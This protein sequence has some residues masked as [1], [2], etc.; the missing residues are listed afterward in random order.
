MYTTYSILSE[1]IRSVQDSG[2]AIPGMINRPNFL[3]KIN[4]E[5]LDRLT[6]ELRSNLFLPNIEI[7]NGLFLVSPDDEDFQ[8]EK[9]FGFVAY[10]RDIEISEELQIKMVHVRDKILSKFSGFPSRDIYK[11]G[12]LDFIDSTTLWNLDDLIPDIDK[13]YID[14]STGSD[15]DTEYRICLVKGDI[16]FMLAF[17]VSRGS[18]ILH[19][20]DTP[21]EKDKKS[22]LELIE[23][24]CDVIA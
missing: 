14:I 17:D 21:Q 4:P 15:M 5:D 16:R 10:I 13:R 24:F 23:C 12:N 1:L 22:N 19:P 9:F 11:D 2:G 18:C 20:F 8:R 6:S 3:E 7:S